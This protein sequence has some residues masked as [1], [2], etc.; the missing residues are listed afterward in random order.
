MYVELPS[1]S[2]SVSEIDTLNWL[3]QAMELRPGLRVIPDG[4]RLVTLGGVLPPEL[5][6]CL[7][8]VNLTG[9]RLFH[10]L[11][12]NALSQARA[13]SPVLPA[14]PW[15]TG[16]LTL[17]LAQEQAVSELRMLIGSLNESTGEAEMTRVIQGVLKA[18][19]P[20]Y[21]VTMRGKAVTVPVPQVGPSRQETEWIEAVGGLRSVPDGSRA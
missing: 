6:G 7:A 5:Q 12:W 1:L 8:E 15:E 4:G 19:S 17:S 3:R 16:N 13:R 21:V 18:F 2:G 14:L 9:V 20:S 10:L 11:L